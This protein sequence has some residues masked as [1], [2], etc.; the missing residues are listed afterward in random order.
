MERGR[1][2]RL[3]VAAAAVAALA[4]IA[5]LSV[6]LLDERRARQSAD[7]LRGD[8]RAFLEALTNYSFDSLEADTTA[9][10]ERTTGGFQEEYEG[11]IS[12]EAFGKTIVEREGRS[13]GE[14]LAVEIESLS[15]DS[16]EVTATVK[17]TT[18]NEQSAEPRVEFLKFELTMERAEGDWKAS[19][20]DFVQL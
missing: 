8:T 17:R 10:L 13:V 3:A 7:D 18:S 9:V 2:S 4:A 14:V 11:E 1:A 12:D 16:A 6:Q 20:V 15:D 5:F 19:R